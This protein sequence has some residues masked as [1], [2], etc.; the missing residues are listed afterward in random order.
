MINSV[1]NLTA[2]QNQHLAVLQAVLASLVASV[3]LLLLQIR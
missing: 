1:F 3:V 2:A